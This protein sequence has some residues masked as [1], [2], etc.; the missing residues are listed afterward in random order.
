MWRINRC[1]YNRVRL[2]TNIVLQKRTPFGITSLSRILTLRSDIFLVWPLSSSSPYAKGVIFAP[3]HTQGHI[4]TRKNSP[5]RA[6]GP[7]HKPLLD[8]TQHSQETSMPLAGIEPATPASK[9]PWVPAI[10]IQWFPKRASRITC[11]PRSV[12][13]ENVDKFLSWQLWS[14]LIC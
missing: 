12:P 2:Q 1:R 14:L 7:S 11:D 9:R 8:N 10:L 13:K 4:H 6:I 3:D 5:G